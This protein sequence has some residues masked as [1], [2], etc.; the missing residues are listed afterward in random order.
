M[1]LKAVLISLLFA[2]PLVFAN[3]HSKHEQWVGGFAEMHNPDSD[4]L[5]SAG[6]GAG[7]EFGY[8]IS[9]K[10]GTRLEYAR[11]VDEGWL[12]HTFRL[13]AD[14]LYKFDDLYDVYAFGGIRHIEDIAS[15]Q[16]IDLGV[17]KHW[18]L[19]NHWSV[20]TEAALY[21][22]ID[23][24]MLD[25]GIKVG[26]AY[27][28]GGDHK[29]GKRYV[30]TPPP[31]VNIIKQPPAIRV[32]T[33]DSDGDGV[34]DGIDDC[35]RTPAIDKVDSNGC[36]MLKEQTVTV[37]LKALF[38]NNSSKVDNPNHPQFAE[39]A[40]FLARYPNTNAVIQGHTSA[41]GDAAYNQ[42]L[43]EKRANAVRDLLIQTYGVPSRRIS[44]VGYGEARLID[45]GNTP[46]AHRLNRR[47]EAKVSTAKKV[48]VKR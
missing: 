28:F 32:E 26:L 19:T 36:S 10:W 20:I 14:A 16:A 6:T 7:A 37:Q 40:Q 35:P 17:G 18:E 3:G 23:E 11:R 33:K 44:A 30:E 34:E 5:I 24:S 15:R 46:S 48:S 41:Q 22:D 25:T 1:R 9:D 42:W 2:V 47:I 31:A 43:S 45:A 39:F 38:G 12:G 29:M 21:Q 27:G 8:W 13:G 4:N